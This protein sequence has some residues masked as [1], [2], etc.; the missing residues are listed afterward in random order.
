MGIRDFFAR[1]RGGQGDLSER[2]EAIPAPVVDYSA[3]APMAEI[4]SQGDPRVLDDMTL[5]ASGYEAFAA[6]H[7]EWCDTMFPDG[8]PAGSQFSIL[9]EV[10]TF[11]LA[12]Y[13]TP[14]E[15]G[16]YIDWK[17][18]PDEVAASLQGVV[19]KLGF[20]IQLGEV[21]F[22]ES[23]DTFDALVAI[24]QH[25]SEREYALV[26]ID[27]ES[28]SYHLYV[29]PQAELEPLIALGA[30]VGF[31]VSVPGRRSGA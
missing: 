31:A 27:T 4:L 12:G 18:A 11:W 9:R 22:P 28:D 7:R 19:D 10:F 16:A 30:S 20:P 5:L 6:V 8:I 24:A 3:L 29:V 17:E 21:V 25:F 1:R 23:E 14:Y 2:P 26:V 13:E 15:Y